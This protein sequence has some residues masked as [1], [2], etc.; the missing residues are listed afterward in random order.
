MRRRIKLHETTIDYAVKKSKRARRLRVAVYCDS[1]VVV[2]VP[3]D[4]AENKIEHFLRLKAAWV[5]DKMEHFKNL[6][7]T[8]QLPRGKRAYKKYR[9]EALKFAEG[10]IA[11]INKYYKYSYNKIAIK[12]HKSRWDS[13]SKKRNLNFNYR[14]IFLPERLADYI[15]AHELCHLGIF[16]HSRK[17]LALVEKSM[18]DF[19]HRVKELNAL[20]KL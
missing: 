17:F 16:D 18:P 11:D 10:K 4:F 15:I 12:D 5:L 2:T 1:A 7:K 19:R 3:Y 8:I 14:V 13:C 20:V 6:G 9:A